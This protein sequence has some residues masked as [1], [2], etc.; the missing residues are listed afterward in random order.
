LSTNL[1]AASAKN[2]RTRGLEAAALLCGLL[3]CSNLPEIEAGVCG[4]AV[5]EDGEDCD[6][7]ATLVTE[8]HETAVKGGSCRSRGA[9][10][11]CRFDCTELGDGS[12]PACPSG[13][14]CDSQGIC[15]AA[16]DGFVESE[17]F[18]GNPASWLGVTDFDGDGREDLLSLSL[19]DKLRFGNFS[20]HYFDVGGR[21]E[22][23]TFPR[24]GG[25]PVTH[26]LDGD[27]ASDLTF[28]NGSIGLLPGRKDRAWV[29][30]T[31]SS[32]Q[33]P[34][35][36]LRSAN[37]RNERVDFG[38]ALVAITAFPGENGRLEN[39]VYI[40]RA[41]SPFFESIYSFD[42]PVESLLGGAVNADL[43][44]GTES[45]CR[46]L[47]L[48]FQGQTYARVL[49]VCSP[50]DN[51]YGAVWRGRASERR[52]ELPAGAQ[53]DAPP[54]A[55]DLD[56][57][58]HL[59]LLLGASGKL[60]ASYGDGS[61]L[62]GQAAPFDLPFV[63]D[64]GTFAETLRPIAAG[65]FTA[66][67]IADFV[68]P[69]KLLSSRQLPNGANVYEQSQVNYGAP[70]TVAR[71]AD[72]NANGLPDA[73]A[74]SNLESG[75]AFFNGTREPYQIGSVIATDGPVSH[76]AVDDFDGDLVN[77]VA[78]TRQ[79]PASSGSTDLVIAFGELSGAPKSVVQVAQ[80][81]ADV[82]EIVPF[83][84]IAIGSMLMNWSSGSGKN[85]QAE[86]TLLQGSSD[87]LPF[88][89]RALVSFG[90][91][92]NLSQASALTLAVGALTKKGQNDGLA[93]GLEVYPDEHGEPQVRLQFWLLEDM[94]VTDVPP[95]RVS[96]KAF[97]PERRP[98][99][100]EGAETTISTATV[101]GDF[102]GD[103]RDESVWVMPEGDDAGCV[104]AHYV[105]DAAG[106]TITETH[107]LHFT[108]PCPAPAV[109]T[110]DLDRDG[111]LDLLLSIGDESVAP[112]QLQLLWNDGAGRFSVDNRTLVDLPGSVRGF[113]A[114][115]GRSLDDPARLAVVTDLALYR[116]TTPLGAARR[117]ES[118]TELLPLLDGLS[119]VVTDHNG[120]D[121]PDMVASDQRGIFLLEAQLK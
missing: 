69:D 117:Y 118:V 30:A 61:E 54:L 23:H 10:H 38:T 3:A 37:V 107:A 9:Q 16:A 109:E 56:G 87:R 60:F 103:G 24:S 19:T 32:Y 116:V 20:L 7:F 88:A 97:P 42:E 26:D 33:V 86:A 57:N 21:V 112:R 104:L 6:T 12:R 1:L 4:N 121:L 113:H 119:V 67:G 98:A 5:V 64:V 81:R 34:G 83:H 41:G 17:P 28:S 74:A 40:T 100:L 52:I 51:L 90:Y 29:P 15:R 35:A 82:E 11:E 68:L 63:I 105:V 77:D 49:D 13:W 48:A 25:R 96:P 102:D 66:D 76:L 53:L 45:P 108:E 101:A 2:R 93:L 70:W 114:Y 78:F 111:A 106:P 27:G 18:D 115:A 73:I 58:G 31:F 59:D 79:R 91:D 14:G 8:T 84:E 110:A 44:E 39:G 99:V 85:V 75:I 43:S 80:V 71:I 92:G 120:D 46:E 47:V 72:V 95:R 55:A 65:D 62:Q 50:A 89:P 94:G 22:R 36:R